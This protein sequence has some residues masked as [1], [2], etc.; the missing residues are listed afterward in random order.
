MQ[1]LLNAKLCPIMCDI[2][3]LGIND[4]SIMLHMYHVVSL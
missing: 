4:I 3:M 2:N 1:S